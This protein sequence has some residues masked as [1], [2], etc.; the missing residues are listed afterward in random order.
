MEDGKLYD[1]AF[2]SVPAPVLCFVSWRTMLY[3][4][5]SPLACC[6]CG[7]VC[8]ILLLDDCIATIGNLT[9]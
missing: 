8:T 6:F 4:V 5:D 2:V 3:M 7:Y 9:P 1:D